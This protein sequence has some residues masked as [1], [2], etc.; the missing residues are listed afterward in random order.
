MDSELDAAGLPSRRFLSDSVALQVRNYVQIAYPLVVLFVYLFAFTVRSIKTSRRSSD[1]LANDEP[2]QLGPNGKPLPAP[3]PKKD[4][5]SIR[6]L[7]FSRARKLL[8][9]WLTVGVACSLLGNIIVVIVHALYSRK[10]GWWC[11]V[12][13][14]VSL[15][16]RLRQIART[17]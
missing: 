17:Y 7:D 11:G 16:M 4:G 10:E 9:Q 15:G 3:K 1:A 14:V 8:F 6:A 13:P 12:A 2:R 5:D